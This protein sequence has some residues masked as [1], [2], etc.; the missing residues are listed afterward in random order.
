MTSVENGQGGDCVSVL[1]SGDNKARG[2]RA[3]QAWVEGYHA[4]FSFNE[5]AT[6]AAEGNKGKLLEVYKTLW[7]S[8]PVWKM[9]RNDSAQRAFILA[10]QAGPCC[11]TPPI[12]TE[13]CCP[14]RTMSLLQTVKLTLSRLARPE[15]YSHVCL[16]TGDQADQFFMVV[17]EAPGKFLRVSNGLDSVQQATKF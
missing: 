15:S 5:K 2:M 4:G 10:A 7:E 14:C 3:S 12:A 11:R 17:R 1:V 6:K 16:P 9:N 8:K 13:S